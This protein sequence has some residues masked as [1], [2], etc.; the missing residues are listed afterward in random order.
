MKND[1]SNMLDV[2]RSDLEAVKT[3]V[4]ELSK[5]SNNE[6]TSITQCLKGELSLCGMDY[7][8][9]LHHGVYMYS[10]KGALNMMTEADFIQSLTQ[11]QFY[12]LMQLGLNPQPPDKV[13]EFLNNAD[14]LDDDFSK[15]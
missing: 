3:I 14:H 9:Y 6:D 7:V 8:I 5:Y 10:E 1:N 15:K 2:L 12:S 13:Q 11:D 4:C